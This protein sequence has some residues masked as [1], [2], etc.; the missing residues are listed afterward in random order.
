MTDNQDFNPPHLPL[1]LDPVSIVDNSPI[2]RGMPPIAAALAGLGVVGGVTSP[3]M[4]TGLLAGA[5]PVGLAGL[6]GM[7]YV[8]ARNAEKTG[9]RFHVEIDITEDDLSVKT[10]DAQTG[11]PGTVFRVRHGTHRLAVYRIGIDGPGM[12]QFLNDKDQGPFIPCPLLYEEAVQVAAM[13]HD[14]ITYCIT[15]YHYR[16]EFRQKAVA[17]FA[18]SLKTGTLPRYDGMEP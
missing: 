10:I 6:V 17:D 16:E 1:R 14:A 5:L 18:E 9:M 8:F 15:P 7:S 12:V 4:I 11:E 2:Y 3:D 13:L